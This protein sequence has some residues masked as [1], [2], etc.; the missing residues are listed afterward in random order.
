MTSLDV[1]PTIMDLMGLW[2][3]P[4][5]D[6][7]RPRIVGQSL[8][9]GGST[10]DP[11]GSAS[12]SASDA[13]PSPSESE[14]P[15]PSAP[16]ESASP[17]ASPSATASR[18][19]PTA[20]VSASAGPDNGADNSE[21]ISEGTVLRRGDTGSEVTELQ[22][23]LRQLF[24]YNGEADGTFSSEV[25][26]SLRNYQFS[27]GTTADGLGVYGAL[28]RAKLESETKEP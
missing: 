9:R 21:P 6:R 16:E 13:S 8:L 28:T 1:F 7:F 12:P 17:S 10:P 19:T 20:R 15:S 2:D 23:R 18:A 22:L 11:S 25:E 5:I 24:L 3:A 26:E 27:R 14:S 4:E